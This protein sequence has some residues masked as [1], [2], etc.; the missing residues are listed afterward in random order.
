MKLRLVFP[1]LLFCMIAAARAAENVKELLDFSTLPAAVRAVAEEQTAGA[2]IEEVETNFEDGKQVHEVEFEK[3]GREMAILISP[4]GKLVLTREEIL[5]KNAP[6]GLAAAVE[7]AA[8]GAKIEKTTK[9]TEEGKSH[10][11]VGTRV[12]GKF[13]ELV[14]E[15]GAVEK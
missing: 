10:Y 9:L 6:A 7:A 15:A 1:A 3:E 4:D 14:L 11:R 5:M 8:P 2:K 12:E 13:K